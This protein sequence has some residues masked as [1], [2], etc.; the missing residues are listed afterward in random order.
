MAKTPDLTDVEQ[1]FMAMADTTRLRLLNLMRENEVCVC[2]FTEVLGESQPKI[3][4]HLAY[5][6]NSGVVEARRDGKWMHYRILWPEE[7]E[8]KSVLAAALD[9][10]ASREDM[11]QDLKTY[12]K[13]CCTPELLM[14]IARTPIDF[15][16]P[17]ARIEKT[18]IREEEPAS[19]TRQHEHHNELEEFLL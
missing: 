15:I 7:D 13:V 8:A 18:E 2:F 6:R 16:D 19:Q 1:F 12:E 3:S 4:R 11:R 10:M 14:Q 5:L 9:W 17:P